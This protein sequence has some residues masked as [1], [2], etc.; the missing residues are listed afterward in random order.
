M[1]V[2]GRALGPV[3]AII[4]AL[5]GD[6]THQPVMGAYLDGLPRGIDSHP[7]LKAK[8]SLY[9]SIV[10]VK[11]L[12]GAV[13]DALPEPLRRLVRDPAPVSQ[14]IPEVHS[15]A[16]MLAVYDQHFDSLEAFERFAYQRQRA[17]FTG[18]LYAIA[19]ELATPGMLLKT[20][21]LRWRLFHRGVKLRLV[22]RWSGGGSV[23]LEH[24][25][26]V[27]EDHSRAGL[28]QG[29]KAALD[30]AT[31]DSAEVD[32]TEATPSHALFVARWGGG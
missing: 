24:P 25:P 12:S 5:L 30:L 10:D 19:L 27:Y 2:R 1:R 23:R 22:E 31:H 29:L 6:D 32:V 21:T 7:E 16:L 18:P 15:H 11:P 4:R 20:A 17:L 14:W 13:I 8:A 26:G 9:R 3:F 28:R